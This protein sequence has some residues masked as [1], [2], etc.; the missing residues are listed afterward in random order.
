MIF[1][2]LQRLLPAQ[3]S[4]CPQEQWEAH[5]CW[6]THSHFSLHMVPQR[7]FALAW[8]RCHE[9]QVAFGYLVQSLDFFLYI[10]G[11]ILQVGGLEVIGPDT[12]KAQKLGVWLLNDRHAT[13]T[14]MK[15]GS[16][17]WWEMRSRAENL[18]F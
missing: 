5:A 12:A 9:L 8:T 3:Q 14:L 7:C 16:I 6:E 2:D 1:Y 17:L 13:Q 10:K 11:S 15:A 4:L 18:Q